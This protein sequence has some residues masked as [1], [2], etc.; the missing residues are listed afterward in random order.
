MVAEEKV[1]EGGGVGEIGCCGGRA[2]LLLWE[3]G[4]PGKMSCLLIAA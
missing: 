1:R 4:V 3:A 2:E